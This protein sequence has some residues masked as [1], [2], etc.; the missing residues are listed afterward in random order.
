MRP[1]AFIVVTISTVVLLCGCLELNSSSDGGLAKVQ[2]LEVEENTVYLGLTWTSVD[3]VDGYR[4]MRDGEQVGEATVSRYNDSDL[5]QGIAYSYRVCGIKS[6]IPMGSQTGPLSEQCSGMLSTLTLDD[7]GFRAFV[8]DTGTVI[9]EICLDVQE[10]GMAM[11]LS[12]SQNMCRLLEERA[13]SYLAMS[14]DFNITDEMVLAM[15]EYRLA[16]GDFIL[17]GDLMDRG[18][19]S[20]DQGM[21]EE[22]IDLSYSGAEHLNHVVN[23]L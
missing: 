5:D 8:R 9:R 2:G 15:D 4:I 7:D 6:L 19:S 20:L 23:M 21:I 22:G 3:G 11:D 13:T 18:I 10:A 16:M 14:W 1:L 12:G 17:S